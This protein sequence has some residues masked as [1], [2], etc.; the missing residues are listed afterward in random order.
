MKTTYDKILNMKAGHKTNVL[1]AEEIMEWTFVDSDPDFKWSMP[2][3][4]NGIVMRRRLPEFSSDIAAAL[5]V[6]MEMNAKG[7]WFYCGILS[8]NSFAI[9]VRSD[10]NTMPPVDRDKATSGVDE[11]SLAICRAALLMAIQK[12]KQ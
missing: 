5:E 7:Y 4:E 11:L 12:G 3:N 1:M 8:S 6:A 2:A 9:F 10:T